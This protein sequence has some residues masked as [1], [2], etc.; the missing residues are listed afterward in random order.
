MDSECS[1]ISF[2]FCKRYEKKKFS[3]A[4]ALQV[5]ADLH[6]GGDKSNELVVLEYEQIKQQ[7]RFSTTDKIFNCNTKLIPIR[8]LLIGLLRAH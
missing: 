7:V 4:E 3:E 5:L 1:N 8:F 6:G 2:R